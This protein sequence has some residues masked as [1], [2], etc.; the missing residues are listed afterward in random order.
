[1]AWRQFDPLG[2]SADFSIFND[3]LLGKETDESCDDELHLLEFCLE[4]PDLPSLVLIFEDI[5][6][7]ALLEE[8]EVALDISDVKT[9][10]DIA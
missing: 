2:Y 8:R 3:T 4:S 5:L 6:S 7:E 9:I 1:V 10:S